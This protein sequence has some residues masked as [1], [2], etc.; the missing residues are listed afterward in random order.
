MAQFKRYAELAEIYDRIMSHVDYNDWA[1]YISSIFKK[2]DIKVND[3]LE[4]A[5]GTGNLSVILHGRGYNVTSTDL[6]LNMLQCARNKFIENKMPLKL[7]VSDMSSLPIKANYDAV[8]CLYDSVNYLLEP[9]LLL[10]A[11]SGVADSLKKGGIYIFDICT[12][13]NSRLFF[14]NHVIS[15]DFG[16]ISYERTCLYYHADRIQE[17]SFN[18]TKGSESIYEK[19]LQKI[20]KISEI[21]NII[22]SGEFKLLGVFDDMSFNDGSEDSER[23][24]FVLKRR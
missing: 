21:K 18:I 5:C 15:E 8:I 10:K 7:L 20:Y 16:D 14:S 1:N 6:S 23:V 17:N 22:P 4:I 24:H 2:F 9:E 12:I 11:F 13:K 3:I 19:H